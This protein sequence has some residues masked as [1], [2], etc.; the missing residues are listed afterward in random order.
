MRLIALPLVSSAVVGLIAVSGDSLWIDEG[1]SATKAIAPTVGAAW[2]ELLTEGNTNM[3]ML[4]YMFCLWAWEKLF[5]SSEWS[6]R[7]MNIPFFMLGVT[8]LWLAAREKARAF[9]LVLCLVSPFLWFYLNEARTYSMLF[10]WS[11]LATAALVYWQRNG[12]QASFPWHRWTWV[13]ALSSSAMIWTHVVGLFFE[14]AIFAFLLFAMRPSGLWRLVRRAPLAVVFAISANVALAAYYLW[15]KSQGIEANP[16]GRT[17]LMGLLFWVYEF[18]GFAGLGPGRDALRSGSFEVLWNYATPLFLLATA[19]MTIGW[20]GLRQLTKPEIAATATI[21]SFLVLLPL[22]LFLVAGYVE[23]VRFLPRYAAT[24]YGAFAVV[25]A[26]LLCSAWRAGM[27]G[28]IASTAVL[29]VLLA[30]SLLLRFSPEHHKDDYRD[31]TAQA[32]ASL[33]RGAHVWWAGDI[34]TARYYGLPNPADVPRNERSFETAAEL[35]ASPGKAPD[36]V[37]LSKL[38]IYD[39]TS[40]IR[41]H[42]EEQGYQQRTGPKTFTIWYKPRAT[43]LP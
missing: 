14:V 21:A 7:A 6:L 30:S 13:L 2:Q 18:A 42:L 36:I 35:R 31:A 5:G 12:Q 4:L 27:R 43:V 22:A 9:V 25:G 20:I 8:A 1:L 38:D 17:S 10:G 26:T 34:D 39:P 24:S 23:G 3:H 29:G 32:L 19:W 15:T 28:K 11:A 33:R 37:Y 40:N 16:I 41:N